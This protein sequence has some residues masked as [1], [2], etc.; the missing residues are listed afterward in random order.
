MV[1]H[2][3]GS[4]DKIVH[5]MGSSWKIFKSWSKKM[6]AAMLKNKICESI[7]DC[8]FV[9]SRLV[10]NFGPM[11][12]LVF[13]QMVRDILCIQTMGMCTKLYSFFVYR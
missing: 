12:S 13:M 1:L 7:P 3:T 9:P 4:P 6:F 5:N 11:M 10:L 8:L 2:C